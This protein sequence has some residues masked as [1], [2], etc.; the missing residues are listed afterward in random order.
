MLRSANP[1]MKGG[2]KL[3]KVR[4]LPVVKTNVFQAD[5]QTRAVAKTIVALNIP[6]VA[7]D[8]P[9][10]RQMLQTFRAGSSLG[11]GR[12]LGT[13]VLDDLF[14]EDRDQWAQEL[15]GQLVAMSCDGWT[16][17]TGKPVFGICLQDQLYAAHETVGD[18]H[19]SDYLAAILWKT[20]TEVE[21]VMQA[22]VVSL[23][24]DSASNMVL[25]RRIL[26]ESHP[27]VCNPFPI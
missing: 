6:L 14:Q 3:I 26:K 19:T 12:T 27:K 25:A 13:T 15:Q 4:T 20:I 8:H 1:C 22:K 5:A 23:V 17:P 24:T 21:S 11:C 10:W 18:P 9:V 2:W 16:S 7:V